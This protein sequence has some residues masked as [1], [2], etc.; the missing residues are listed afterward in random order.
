MTT[1]TLE[2]AMWLLDDLQKQL[3]AGGS[4]VIVRDGEP[5]A[6]LTRVGETSAEAPM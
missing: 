4:I 5:V 6:L 3:H 1:V 2:E